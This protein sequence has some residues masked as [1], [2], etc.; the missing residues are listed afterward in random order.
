[1]MKIFKIVLLSFVICH[2][3]FVIPA[4]AGD[5][6]DPLA[7]G[8]GARSIGMGKAYV[9]MA[10]DGDA[11]FSNPAG[12]ASILTPKVSSMQTSL[13]G[14]VSYTVIG[15]AYPL[16]TKAAIGAGYAASSTGDIVLTSSAGTIE[17]TG[18]WGQSVLF[19]SYGRYLND[20]PA[21]K[22]LKKDVLVGASLKYYGVGGSGNSTIDS[23]SGNAY[24][25]DLGI[26]V[27]TNDYLT[28]GANYQNALKGNINSDQL[29]S[30]LKLGAKASLIGKEGK[31]YSV[32]SDR[33][34]YAN[35]DYD[36]GAAYHLGLEFWANKNLALRTGI[37]GS[38]LTAGLGVR[39][40]GVEFNYAYH[41]YNGLSNDTSHFFSIGYLGE[42]IK[43]IL[44]VKLDKAN[45]KGI[46]Y[47]DHV[48]LKGKV[49]IA[50]GTE[51]VPATDK[52][53][54][55]VNGQEVELAED[56]SFAADVTLDKYG[57]HLVQVKVSDSLGNT[58]LDN[59]RVVRLV[60]FDD[61]PEG[62]WAQRPIEDTG[63]V[64]LVQGYP[65]D[66]F[67]PDRSLTR[68]EIATLLVRAKGL[69]LPEK[70]DQIFTDVKPDFWAARYIQVAYAN[71]LMNGYPDSS[72][73]PNNKLS[74][75]EGIAV[76]ARFDELKTAS[77]VEKPYWD[78][79]ATHWSAKYI[80]A[81]KDAGLLKF[82]DEN[83]LK[84]NSKM[85][86]SEAIDML[87]KTALANGKITDLYSWE[88]GKKSAPKPALIGKKAPI[89]PETHPEI[90]KNIVPGIK[91]DVN[92]GVVSDGDIEVIAVE[93]YQKPIYGATQASL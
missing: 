71:E 64:G 82:A 25:A 78:V 74:I 16:G 36:L 70:A 24:G 4:Y 7:I 62:Y 92:I 41:P 48:V 14:D 39:M 73:R 21:F 6:A 42:P 12:L 91:P 43:R 59:I 88:K 47:E 72:F 86:R 65:D 26:L 54:V 84:P 80:Q 1:M 38:E 76:L 27:P 81:A 2:L 89:V 57:K 40:K 58:D 31:A 8:V 32:H 28:L 30:T 67:R 53:T 46:T 45:D 3:S 35:L 13:M 49:E 52:I 22:K 75:A 19:V 56:L 5:I 34:L 79:S 87:A 66:T 17:G 50:E 77:V 18:N 63:T 68:A 29:P 85:A 11:L 10:E 51:D 93:Q 15:G 69:E 20:L 61:V 33:K 37:D 83:K 9:A 55:L 60:N 44:R 23:A 90:V